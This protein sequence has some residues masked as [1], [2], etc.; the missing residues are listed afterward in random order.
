[1][2]LFIRKKTRRIPTRIRRGNNLYYRYQ[3]LS[4]MWKELGELLEQS[5]DQ[6]KDVTAP[7]AF[8]QAAFY[9]REAI[10]VDEQLLAKE[11]EELEEDEG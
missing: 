6:N 4:E 11:K 5:C 8:S 2:G 7:H 10:A 9:K 1:M 3:N